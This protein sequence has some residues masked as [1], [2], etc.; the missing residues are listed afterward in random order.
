MRDGNLGIWVRLDWILALN[1][2][3]ILDLASYCVHAQWL[4]CIDILR[5]CYLNSLR[6][7][8]FS[9]LQILL[10]SAIWIFFKVVRDG[11]RTDPNIRSFGS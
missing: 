6:S 10:S 9:T 2:T 5:I 11:L 4:R 7:R 1:L 3:H 8:T